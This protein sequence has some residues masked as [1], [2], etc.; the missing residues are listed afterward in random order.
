MGTIAYPKMMRH[1]LGHGI[2]EPAVR[3]KLVEDAVK[4]PV[5]NVN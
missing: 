5:V 3:Q 1:Q 2:I 4:V